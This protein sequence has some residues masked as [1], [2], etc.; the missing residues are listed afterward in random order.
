MTANAQF[1]SGDRAVPVPSPNRTGGEPSVLR[2]YTRDS[3]CGDVGSV[4]R[5]V[6]PSLDRSARS[7]QSNQ[8]TSRSL[9]SPGA[10]ALNTKRTLSCARRTRPSRSMSRSL[11]E[12][13]T[14]TSVRCRPESVTARSASRFPGSAIVNQ[15]SSPAGDQARPCAARSGTSVRRFPARSITAT[16]AHFVYRVPL[17]D[18]VQK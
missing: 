17:P 9:F 2:R 18:R 11:S 15:I 8:D 12:P 4:K 6:L 13:G 10:S 7:D 1:P 16:D 14:L 5:T 3:P